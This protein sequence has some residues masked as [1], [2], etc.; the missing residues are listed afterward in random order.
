MNVKQLLPRLLLV[1][2]VAFQVLAV[3]SMV[4]SREWILATGE[5]WVFQTAPVDPRDIFRGDYV[6]LDYLFSQVSVRQLEEGILEK[7]LYKGQKVYLSLQ[8]DINGVARAGRLTTTPPAGEAYLTG[9]STAHWP[10][11]RYNRE[12]N[13]NRRI[14]Q[15]R[16][17]PVKYGIE[18]F[19]VQQGAGRAMEDMR[20]NRDAFQLPLLI[21]AGVSA[22]GEAVIRSYEWSNLATKTEIVQSP[23]RDAPDEQA[24]AIM[25]FTLMNRSDRAITLPLKTGNCSF[26]LI[27]AQQAPVEATG[28]V[29]ERRACAAAEV[30]KITLAPNE[31]HAV[32]FDLNQPHWQVMHDNAPTPPG[33][34]PWDYRYRIQY[35]GETIPEVNA[36]IISRAF[37]GGGDID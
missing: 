14:E 15:L 32:T 11:R 28:F 1:L 21:H 37:H 12:A 16:P 13:E 9:R 29:G 20:G 31:T 19:Y 4:I 33:K 17:V 34:L 35:Q 22:S 6:R 5:T 25:R 18:Q 7:G 8:R 27:P 36:M 30:K 23:R 3:A 24:S 2:A 10:Y 26:T